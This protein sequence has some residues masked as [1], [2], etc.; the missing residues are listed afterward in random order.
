MD[1]SVLYLA[2][3]TLAEQLRPTATEQLW[4]LDI[5]GFL[6]AGLLITMGNLGDRIGRRR[7][8]L[9]GSMVFGAGSVIAAFAPDPAVLIAA[10]ALMGVGGATLMPATLSLITN[11]FP[12]TRIRSRAIGVW[13]AAFAGGSAIGPVVGGVLLHH[14][15]WGSVF[16][17]NVPVLV[18]FLAFA[19]FLVPEYRSG[20]GDPFDVAGIVLSLAAILPIVYAIKHLAA[21]GVDATGVVIGLFGVAMLIAFVVQQRRARFP[22]VD[23]TLFGNAGFTVAVLVALLGMLS[24]SAMFYLTGIYLQTVLDQDVLAAA[25][26]GIPAAI[27]VA[28]F[29]VGASRLV[30]ALGVRWTFVFALVAAA[31]GNAGL[32]GLGV[33]QGLWLYMISTSI[34]GVGYG[35][36][37]SVVSEVAVAAVPVH[38]SGAA[39]G[40]SE[41]CF[42]LGSALG[43]AVLGS[44]ATLVFTRE[45]DGRFGDTLADTL[46][47]AATLPGTQGAELAAAARAA[48]VDGLHVTSIVNVVTLLLIVVGVY[49]GLRVRRPRALRALN[50]AADPMPELKYRSRHQ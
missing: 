11:M 31:V 47:H 3:P 23:L 50:R 29:S 16:L 9:V 43:L 1:M 10:R 26:A 35:V 8:L 19:P 28:A 4:I 25:L 48:F 13:T 39:A 12:D 49:F 14:F 2:T 24:L 15:W 18:V 7:V 21:E 17:I 42:E 45:S 6:I 20:S 5:Y 38:R 46:D 37:F 40:I 41:T 33:S 34:A 27:T 44:L 22:L 32:I 30:A 36:M